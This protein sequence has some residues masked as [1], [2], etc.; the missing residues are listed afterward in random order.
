[1][2]ENYIYYFRKRGK[3]KNMNAL[4]YILVIHFLVNLMFAIIFL[5][6]QF[7]IL[8]IS[9]NIM[10]YWCRFFSICETIILLITRFFDFGLFGSIGLGAFYIINI[11]LLIL[12]FIFAEFGAGRKLLD[13]FWITFYV[14]LFM[15]DVCNTSIIQVIQQ[16]R[17]TNELK[18][19]DSFL[20]ETFAGKLVIGIV[21]PV[22]RTL[23]LEA[24]HKEEC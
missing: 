1:M 23:L 15:N 19:I 12:Q 4:D 7:D 3:K 10:I 6:Y 16:F 13:V 20:N 21:A 11:I 18:Q 14:L 2:W 24:I 8:N 9:E 5:L 22:C 17:Y